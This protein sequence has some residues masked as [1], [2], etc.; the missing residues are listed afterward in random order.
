M[1]VLVLS[2]GDLFVAVGVVVADM[3]VFVDLVEDGE[4][5]GSVGGVDE[6]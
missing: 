2:A 5:V 6:R 3:N 1:V 4:F